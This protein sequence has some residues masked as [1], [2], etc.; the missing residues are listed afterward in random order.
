MS[1][2]HNSFHYLWAHRK[3]NS[4]WSTI[5]NDSFILSGLYNSILLISYLIQN[6][7]DKFTH[8]YMLYKT[9]LMIYT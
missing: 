9:N 5:G 6:I 2:A 1:S 7:L 8:K 3:Q 4:I